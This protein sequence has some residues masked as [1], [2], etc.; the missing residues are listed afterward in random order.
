MRAFPEEDATFDKGELLRQ[1]K[2]CS[3]G[4]G[5]L[6]KWLNIP[7][8]WLQKMLATGK[9]NAKVLLR[10][11]RLLQ[12]KQEKVVEPGKIR[13]NRKSTEHFS[14]RMSVATLQAMVKEGKIDAGIL[15]EIERAKKQP[16]NELVRFLEEIITGVE[17][18]GK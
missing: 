12:K 15:K 18:V 8:D 17:G 10:A 6:S 13:L 5:T 1:M 9:A 14:Q 7:P 4:T 16:R 3:C 2:R 11:E